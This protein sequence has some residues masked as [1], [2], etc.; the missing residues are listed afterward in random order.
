M[1]CV[2]KHKGS[3]LADMNKEESTCHVFKNY[4]Q[5][6]FAGVYSACFLVLILGLLVAVVFGVLCGN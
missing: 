6:G 2:L 4:R 1:S 5:L 3:L